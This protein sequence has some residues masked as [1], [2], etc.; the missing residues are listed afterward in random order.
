MCI[1]QGAAKVLQSESIKSSNRVSL[2]DVLRG[3]PK[4]LPR[5][6]LNV[7]VRLLEFYEGEERERDVEVRWTLPSSDQ[8]I[9]T[10][11]GDIQRYVLRS[12]VKGREIEI[13]NSAVGPGRRQRRDFC[14]NNIIDRGIALRRNLGL[15]QPETVSTLV[16]GL[17]PGVTCH[18]TVSC[19]AEV[20]GCMRESPPSLMSNALEIPSFEEE[21][22]NMGEILD[23][24]FAYGMANNSHPYADNS[25]FYGMK[26]TVEDPVEEKK[27]NIDRPSK[28]QIWEIQDGEN[29]GR[30]H[31]VVCEDDKKTP[32]VTV[33]EEELNSIIPQDNSIEVPVEDSEQF[34]Q[35]LLEVTP[36]QG[37]RLEDIS[38]GISSGFSLIGC[39]SN[40]EMSS[41]E[42]EREM[43]PENSF[44]REQS[45][46]NDAILLNY[47]KGAIRDDGRCDI[48]NGGDDCSIA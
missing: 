6:P 27:K 1:S 2:F 14:E 30:L 36:D 34:P 31:S 18:F 42:F 23:K 10:T 39:H 20:Q 3:P 8:M 13:M 5:S 32:H 15:N 29:A 26:L 40:K 37:R 22:W 9:V 33:D 19:I 41:S 45:R 16:H 43:Q 11:C 21:E 38:Q 35:E 28:M 24:V 7:T 12:Y 46:I 47:R 44:R 4:L 17:T 48:Q 25:Y